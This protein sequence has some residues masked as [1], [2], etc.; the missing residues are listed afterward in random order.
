MKSFQLGKT[1]QMMTKPEILH[2]CLFRSY[3]QEHVALSDEEEVIAIVRQLQLQNLSFLTSGH[4]IISIK[5]KEMCLLIANKVLACAERL[6]LF[7]HLI[8]LVYMKEFLF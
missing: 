5:F 7:W 2:L 4:C 8:C 6:F 1:Q 3:C